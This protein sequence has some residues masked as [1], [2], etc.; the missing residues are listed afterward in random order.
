MVDL[1]PGQLVRSLAGRDKGK[2]YLVLK[3]LNEKYVLLV[4]GRSRTV[5]QPKK[6]NK[7]HLQHYDRRVDDEA[8]FREERATDSQVIRFINELLDKTGTPDEEV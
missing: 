2:H 6:K 1:K 7:I 8:L 3:E 5:H 4:D